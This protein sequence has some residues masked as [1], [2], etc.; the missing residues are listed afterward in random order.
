M[1]PPEKFLLGHRV[2]VT[3]EESGTTSL[4]QGSFNREVGV[5]QVLLPCCG[6]SANSCHVTSARLMCEK[7]NI[8]RLLLCS[9][10]AVE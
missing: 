4:M 7:L 9:G 2:D 5:A 6:A 3:R 1:Q 10:A 8:V